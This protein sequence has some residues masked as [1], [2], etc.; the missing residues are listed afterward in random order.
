VRR[1]SPNFDRLM[2]FGASIIRPIS[3]AIL[4]TFTEMHKFVPNYG[5]VLIIFSILLKIVLTPLTNI[6]TRSMKEMQKIQPQLTSL[7]EKYGSDQQRMNNERLK[8]MRDT[9]YQSNGRLSANTYSDAGA[10]GVVYRFRT[11]IELRQ[12][13][14][15]SG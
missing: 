13:L 10:M 8:L 12:A 2:N 15:F 3:K 9:Q 6:T 7:Q 11:T 14:L 5:W 4:W 1:A